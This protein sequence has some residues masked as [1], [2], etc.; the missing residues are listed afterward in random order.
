MGAVLGSSG[1]LTAATP[2]EIPISTQGI[3]NGSFSLGVASLSTTAT[4][5]NSREAGASTPQLIITT[6]GGGGPTGDTT[7]PTVPGNLRA[8]AASAGEVRLTW[9]ASDDAV[10]VTGYDVFRGG[11]LLTS[12]GNLTS[13][14]DRSVAPANTYSYQVR[15]KDAATNLSGL[16]DPAS[17]TTPA[18]GGTVQLIATDDATI[19]QASPTTNYGRA[20]TLEV[21][22]SPVKNV[23]LRFDLSSVGTQTVTRAV[24]RLRVTDSSSMGGS[25]GRLA[26][27]SWNEGAVTW[28]T[29]PA[30][31][32][33]VAPVL[34]GSVTSGTTVDVDVT[35]L[36]NGS[37]LGLRVSSTSS[38]GA[39]YSSREGTFAPQLVLTLG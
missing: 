1:R 14:S 8:V 24:L 37:T 11:A 10:G 19:Q 4:S 32:T 12:V 31:D 36:V 9:N 18:A 29:A 3:A 26:A 33:S 21:D 27:G 30:V 15:A 34:L 38:N 20:S 2:V 25:F 23:L 17:V 22:N 39:D 6:G 35:R 16:S 5:I 7:P 28:N 13:Y